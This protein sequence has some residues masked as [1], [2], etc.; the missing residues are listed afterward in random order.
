MPRTL[1]LVRHGES[2]GNVAGARD[3]AG[4]P[5]AF[6]EA[7]R[8]TP[9]STWKLTREGFGQGRSSGL[10]Q[11]R[12]VIGTPSLPGDAFDRGYI[13]PHTR[14]RQTMGAVALHV[15]IRGGV[16][17]MDMRLDLRLREQDF[18]DI[19]LMERREYERLYGDNARTRRIDPL[20]WR[21][22]GGESVADVADT[23]VRSY[24]GALARDHAEGVESAVVATHGRY[25]SATQ[26][27]LEGLDPHKWVDYLKTNEIKNG[28][29]VQYTCV[30]PESG[31]E[32]R[33]YHWTRIATPWEAPSD[34]GTWRYFDAPNTMSLEECLEGI[35]E[36][37]KSD[38]VTGY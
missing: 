18:G 34:P 24:I 6:D 31:L 19:S 25:I 8:S 36:D 5:S 1:V 4:D 13:S 12:F 9:S 14:S 10:W 11:N 37:W 33:S 20:Y 35:P 15:P 7:Y 38:P 28:T 29:T 16:A 17:T 2:E 26:V 27:V 30:D 32:A 23:R 3:K 22:P 21:P